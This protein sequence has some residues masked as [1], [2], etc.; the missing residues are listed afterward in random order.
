MN[1]SVNDG[2]H[3]ECIACAKTLRARSYKNNPLRH[4]EWLLLRHFGIDYA[5]YLRLYAKQNGSCAICNKKQDV[6]NVDHDH[7]TGVIR[8]LLCSACNFGIGN[9]VNDISLLKSA[10]SYL[11]KSPKEITLEQ[12]LM[13]LLYKDRKDRQ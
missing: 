1:S 11:E 9:F 6:L 3:G 10:I 7:V 13:K 12:G 2:L 8:G 4:K 5:G